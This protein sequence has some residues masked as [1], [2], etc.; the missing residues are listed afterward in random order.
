MDKINADLDGL[1]RPLSYAR[2]DAKNARKHN[3]KN[4]SAIKHSLDT[5]GQQKPIVICQGIVI[6]GNGTYA[7]AT[8]LGWS[9]LA[10]IEFEDP[11]K[12]RAFALAD[13]RT[14]EL[15]EWDLSVLADD[16][17]DLKALDIDVNA[18]GWENHELEPI[19]AADFKPA[20]PDLGNNNDPLKD[21]MKTFK[22]TNEQ[23]EVVER[24]IKR[25]RDEQKEPKLSAGRCLELICADYLSGVGALS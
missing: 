2:L 9:H 20:P 1:R 19:L 21:T 4:L 25:F 15:A 24:A 18:L 10:M 23:C 22:L 13:N 5:F 17:R 12:A 14:A 3:E 8:A 11:H 7:A 16:L 6:A